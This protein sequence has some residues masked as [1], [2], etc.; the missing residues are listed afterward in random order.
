[1]TLEILL[2]EREIYRAVVGVAR[3]MDDRDWTALEALLLP[4]MTADMGTGP[5]QGSAAVIAM[6]RSF[7]DDCGP[8]QHLLGNVM[9]DVDGDT[10]RSRAYVSDMHVGVDDKAGRTFST[11]GDYHDQWRRVE[12]RWRISHRA[13]LNRAHIGS[14]D[15]LGPGPASWQG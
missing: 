6:I 10:A 14:I 5:L 8:T 3:A 4:D 1:M 12:G 13:K 11:L 2:A 9:I 15:V 7:L